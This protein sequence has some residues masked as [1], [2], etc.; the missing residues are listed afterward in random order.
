MLVLEIR[1]IK[2]VEALEK[3]IRGLVFLLPVMLLFGIHVV[4]FKIP[5]MGYL[6]L[7]RV[8]EWTLVALTAAYFLTGG[9]IHVRPGR[10][11]WYAAVLVVMT[12]FAFVSLIWA[13]DRDSSFDAFMYQ[14]TG[15]ASV[16]YI[17]AV[18]R[19]RHDLR[20]FLRVLTICY[21]LVAMFGI[22]EIYTGIY[23]F[24]PGVL[25]YSLKDSFGFNF[26]YTV[27]YNTN[28]HAS[29]LAIFAPFAIYTVICWV[30]GIKGKILG[31]AL[32][33]MVFFNFLCGRA[34]NSFITTICFMVI[35]LLTCLAKKDIRSYART[36]GAAI[37]ALPVAYCIVR[38]TELA[39]G[40]LLGK[41][42]TINFSDHSIGER[43]EITLGGLRMAYAYHFMGVGVGNSVTLLPYYSGLDPIN[44]HNMPLQILVEYGIIIFAL[45]AIMTALLARDFIKC[46][47]DSKKLRIFCIISF[48][49]VLAFQIEGMQPSDAMHIY[50]LWMVFGVWFAS[51]RI[52]YKNDDK[53]SYMLP[54]FCNHFKRQNKMSEE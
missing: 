27:F 11:F 16:C 41:I 43:L 26:P 42:A 23:L 5:G 35:L 3:A 38:I 17:A 29:F 48:L 37:A 34:R 52:L 36:V 21:A 40:T 13:A 31:F 53:L 32:A 9:R 20:V 24:S 10:A 45:Y 2:I 4:F 39:N 51:I 25:A 19:G 18:I 54:G 50:A 47:P 33:L 15:V 28:D 30:S 7:P 1:R 14:F 49:S 8:Y 6:T 46:R 12:A 22:F 44:L